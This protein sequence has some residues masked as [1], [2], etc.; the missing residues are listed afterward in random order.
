MKKRF[1]LLTLVA[2]A[3]LFLVDRSKT[4][5][6][7]SEKFES[8]LVKNVKSKE[9]NQKHFFDEENFEQ[10]LNDLPIAADLQKLT[11]KEVHHTPELIKDAG[12]L[13]GEV[14][15]KAQVDPAKRASAMKFFKDCAEDNEVVRPIRAVCLKK[16]YKLMPKWK[17][18]TVISHE[19]IPENVSALAFKLL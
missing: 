15:A 18:A 17:I 19:K 13:I 6:V 3:I 5:S 8:T 2:V 11:L 1:I 9:V 7:S 10:E 16:V 4:L 14:H 12:E